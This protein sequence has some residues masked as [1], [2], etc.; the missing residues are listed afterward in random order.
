MDAWKSADLASP[1][2]ADDDALPR[3]QVEELMITGST[4]R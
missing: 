2:E 1:A 4:I 3:G